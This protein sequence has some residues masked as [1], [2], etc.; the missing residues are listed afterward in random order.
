M[1]D[2]VKWL[3]VKG[4]DLPE[5]RKLLRQETIPPRQADKPRPLKLPA[6][7]SDTAFLVEQ[8]RDYIDHCGG[9]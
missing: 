6:E 8:A 3:A 7:L 4:Y 2:W 5:H 9:T 1:E